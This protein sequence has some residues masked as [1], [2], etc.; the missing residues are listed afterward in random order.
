LLLAL[1]VLATLLSLEA[2]AQAMPRD[3][4][5]QVTLISQMSEVAPGQ[6]I[7]LAMHQN[8]YPGWHTYWLNAGDAGAPPSLDW[9]L[10]DGYTAG[11]LN[12]PPPERIPYI[13]LMN[14]GYSDE[15]T[16][17]LQLSVPASAKPGDTVTLSADAQWLVCEEIC[18]PED[19][20]VS[21][22]LKIGET[23]RRDESSA[24]LIEKALATLPTPAPFKTQFDLTLETVELFLASPELALAFQSGNIQEASWFPLE[25]GLIEN[26]AEQNFRATGEGV[27]LTLPRGYET[28]DFASVS[29]M[30]VFTQD[31]PDGTITNAFSFEGTKGITA[32][33]AA[34]A[35][36]AG[37]FAALLR[38]LTF[39]FLGG[40]LLN[41]MPCVFPVLFLKA[42]TFLK[43]ADAEASKLRLEGLSYTAGVVLSF[44]LL[45]ATLLV[46][47][48]GGEAI[49]WGFQLQTPAIV[50]GLAFLLLGVGLS[51]SG[52]ISIGGSIMGV[53]SGLTETKGQWG[54]FFTGVLATIV[55]TPCTAPFMGAAIGFALT[56][57]AATALLVFI[58]LGLGMALPFLLLAFF[59]AL[60]SKL[61][62]PG[63][64][65]ERVKQALAFPMYG[66]AAWLI[67][68]FALQTEPSALL[69]LLLG[70][71][72]FSFGLWIYE[73]TRGT[74][75]VWP[76]LGKGIAV[77]TL[78]ATVI[79]LI[80][81]KTPV[82]AASTSLQVKA[83][84]GGIAY[85]DFSE[86]RVE[87]LTNAGKPVFVNFTAAWC[88]SCL[89][90]EKMVFAS[91]EIIKAF[92]DKGITYLK[93]DWTARDPA[94]TKAL[95][96]F[97]R[98]G[99]PLYLWYSGKPGTEAEILPQILTTG[100][101]MKALE[102]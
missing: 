33:A 1:S 82:S 26:V 102:G 61:P 76:H 58:F 78:V 68:V 2:R 74:E 72:L 101:V 13:D 62:K 12:F 41:I 85:E 6:T 94:I 5:V 17:P 40:I 92:A 31:L 44:A 23:N 73:V 4:V 60:A 77:L 25:P 39:A 86:A 47:R 67:W 59:P 14:F 99:V 100:I 75:G 38:T 7:W 95:A 28:K 66:A 29:G 21:L 50:G 3:P 32:D 63:L 15:V 30:F 88:I 22:R 83:T 98:A 27:W 57:S 45:G 20:K 16:L 65:M 36:M 35:Q 54:S 8:I 80:Q 90:N 81:I 42:L 93:A 64:W 70:L 97:G 89:A 56:Q 91:D 10:P 43:H 19:G 24:P 52:V 9:H 37:G 51:L 96:K 55:A 84:S 69:A 46:L 87:E 49:G 18:I 34:P 53:G 71:V 79:F 48:A 11:D